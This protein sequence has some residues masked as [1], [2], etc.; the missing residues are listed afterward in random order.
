MNDLQKQIDAQK[1]DEKQLIRHLG[2]TMGYGRIMQLCNEIW[3]EKLVE[4]GILGGEFV[5]GPC[6]AFTIPCK[7]PEK[8]ENGHC[9]WC[10]GAGWVTKHAANA[11]TII[12][13]LQQQIKERDE[14]I[15]EAYKCICVG[16]TSE[17]EFEL[18]GHIIGNI[19]PKEGV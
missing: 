15:A 8:D 6:A 19:K 2:D 4:Q 1:K 9:E 3:R 14:V 17:A 13:A 5:Y 10:S 18:R 11:Q 16:K 7:H 12:L